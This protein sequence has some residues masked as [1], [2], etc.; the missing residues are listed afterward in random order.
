MVRVNFVTSIDG[1]ATIK[2]YSAGLGGPSDK[3]VFDLLRVFCDGLMVGA[4]TLRHEGYGP[5]L[6][7]DDHRDRRKRNGLADNPTLV[8][9]SG[10][11]DLDPSHPILADAPVR[12]IVLTHGGSP[13]RQRILLSTVTEVIVCGE[14]RIDFRSAVDT[15]V[16]RGLRHILCEGGPH[17]LG[18]LTAADVVDEMC[19]TV[20]PR[21]AGAGS[22]R[23]T[24]GELSPPRDLTLV[25]VLAAGDELF[26]RYARRR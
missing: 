14:S 24:A 21:L 9:V 7:P 15:L 17:V 6:L 11:L 10:R 22:G 4:G 3:R 19:L 20:S 25:H 2:G 12:P 5:L 13:E 1:A 26:L 16:R 23:I 18:V 8:V